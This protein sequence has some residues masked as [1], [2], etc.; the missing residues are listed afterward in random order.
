MRYRSIVPRR[1]GPCLAAM[2]VLIACGCG[3]HGN[4]ASAAKPGAP[5]PEGAEYPDWLVGTWE[6]LAREG[7]DSLHP[8][9]VTMVVGEDP[10]ATTIV[11]RRGTDTCIEHPRMAVQ[12]RGISLRELPSNGARA[13]RGIAA[14]LRLSREGPDP[15]LQ[16][17]YTFS[18]GNAPGTLR[19]TLVDLDDD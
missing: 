10:E 3:E 5:L 12:S 1:A 9:M 13:C 18:D 14:H 2:L 19:L 8:W 6:G 11:Y 15:I 17:E 7:N 16:G 4:S